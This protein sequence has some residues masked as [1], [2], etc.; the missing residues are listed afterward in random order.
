MAPLVLADL[1]YANCPDTSC[2]IGGHCFTLGSGMISWSS[3]K[4]HTVAGSSCYAE[5]IALHETAHEVTFLRALLSTLH[6][7][8]SFATTIHCDNTAASILTEDH[9]WHLHV[10]HIRVKYHAV[11][12][13]VL[14][15]KVAIAC[16]RSSDNT[17]DILTKSLNCPDFLCLW[18]LLGLSFIT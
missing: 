10:K 16:V 12:E 4:Q 11:R 3:H 18:S 5:Y 8:P 9:I 14:N 2:S 15:G 17:V 13:S 6:L 1:D 7:L